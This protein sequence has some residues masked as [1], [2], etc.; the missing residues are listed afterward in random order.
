M[1]LMK[2]DTD[3]KTPSSP[4]AH[5]LW[6]Y[7]PQSFTFL[8]SFLQ[9]H[10]STSKCLPCIPYFLE[11][12]AITFKDPKLS[13]VQYITERNLAPSYKMLWASRKRKRGI[14]KGLRQLAGQCRNTR[15]VSWVSRKSGGP[16]PRNPKSLV[17][18]ELGE[19]SAMV[20]PP[21]IIYFPWF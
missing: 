10:L 17:Q 4:P 1:V 21:S 12:K 18:A 5:R 7:Q 13:K 14:R 6:Y 8:W 19:N 11:T 3:H 16:A 20:L 9:M 2:V 15:R